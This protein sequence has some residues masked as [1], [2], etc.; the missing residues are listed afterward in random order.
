MIEAPIEALRRRRFEAF[1]ICALI[2]ISLVLPG[3]FVIAAGHARAHLTEWL[4]SYEPIVYVAEG[5]SAQDVEQL[6]DELSRWPGVAE[7]E[8]RDRK[9]ALEELTASLG[10]EQVHHLGVTEV[11]MPTSLH[12]SPSVPLHGHIELVSSAAALETREVV[13]L[14]DVPDATALNFIALLR[15]IMLVSLASCVVLLLVS[16]VM[17]RSFLLELQRDER[18]ELEILEAF[19]A[20]RGAL[21]RPTMIRGVL[22]GVWAGGMA[23]LLLLITQLQVER[24]AF[25][26]TGHDVRLVWTWLVVVAPMVVAPALGALVGRLIVGTVMTT[27]RSSRLPES[28][29]LLAFDSRFAAAP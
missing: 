7:V 29:S 24:W 2:S 15:V 5:T 18:R 6:R 4:T 12:I 26:L 23:S 11:M 10:P 8:V 19:G 22:L 14:V 13:A 25:E 27:E 16:F 9:A 17:S 1:A 28:R 21:L 20:S 3:L